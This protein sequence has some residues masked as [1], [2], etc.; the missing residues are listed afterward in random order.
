MPRPCTHCD[1][2]GT[3]PDPVAR[4]A[5]RIEALLSGT[6]VVTVSAMRAAV[7]AYGDAITARI[8]ALEGVLSQVLAPLIPPPPDADDLFAR[9]GRED[10]DRYRAVLDGT[11]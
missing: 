1:G 11:A 3:E 8:A 5:G 9:M 4:A 7:T 6:D 2:S 10:Y